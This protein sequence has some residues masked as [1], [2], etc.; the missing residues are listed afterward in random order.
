MFRKNYIMNLSRNLPFCNNIVNY[1]R[2]YLFDAFLSTILG[3]FVA[4][5]SNKNTKN[6]YSRTFS[7]SFAFLVK[8]VNKYFFRSSIT[9]SLFAISIF[10]VF[11][12]I[13]LLQIMR[14]T[15]K[16]FCTIYKALKYHLNSCQRLLVAFYSSVCYYYLDHY[17]IVAKKMNYVILGT[18]RVVLA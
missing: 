1:S 15:C 9:P 12:W 6:L 3:F 5:K 10:E 11:C 13:Y 17:F 2:N 7:C 8:F 18:S 16:Y 14:A 4:L